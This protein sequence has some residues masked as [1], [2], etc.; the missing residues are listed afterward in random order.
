MKYIE[1]QIDTK[2]ENRDKILGILYDENLFE[3]E[4]I[5]RDLKDELK[6]NE[7]DWDFFEGENLS[8]EKDQL[9]FRVYPENKNHGE[10]LKKL[11][12]DE[13]LG[14]CKI[15]EK[16]DLD[17]KNAWK[18]YYKPL[19][20]GK[21]LA[22]VPAWEEYENKENRKIIKIE[23]GMA[24]G[25]GTHESTSLCLLMLEK[26]LR[27]KDTV[28]DIGCGS[29]ILAIAAIKLGAKSALL[30]DIDEKC[31]RASEEN[32]I[33]NQVED[34]VSIKKGNLLDTVRGKCDI[35]ISNIIAEIIV[36][37]IKDLKNHLE[38][39]GIFITSGII[40][41]KK[42]LVIDSLKNSGFDILESQGKNGWLVIVAKYV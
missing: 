2:I 29:G 35:I 30:V 31:I 25:T 5:Y 17:W 19:E 14:S 34:I 8:V 38:K 40:K 26:Y 16:D 10:K 41:E 4:E 21:N 24:F 32:A 42:N 20:I 37:E 9:I 7:R 13:N 39:G 15:L 22:I 3:V 12:E 36:D 1:M 6:Q 11:L 28:F 18:A 23:P 33:L 27:P